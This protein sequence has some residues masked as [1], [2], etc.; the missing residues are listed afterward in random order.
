MRMRLLTVF[1]LLTVIS[2]QVLAAPPQANGLNEKVDSL[3][4]VIKETAVCPPGPTRFVDNGDGTICDTQ[5]GLMWEQKNAADGVQ[6]FGNPRDVD[7]TYTWTSFAD[8]DLSNPD[9]TV[10]TDFLPRLNGVFAETANSEQLGVYRDW[11]LPTLAE[12]RTLLPE[13]CTV[14]LCIIDPVFT[15]YLAID[16]S[17]TVDANDPGSAW[18]V[19]FYGADVESGDKRFD[20]HVR[21]VRGG[22]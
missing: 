19:G 5:T 21:A 6:D 10:F 7:N 16:W 9:G 2:T 11:R 15:P 13:V 12:L 20:L 17:S 4:K 8:G 1:L 22:R 18:L 3:I 14:A